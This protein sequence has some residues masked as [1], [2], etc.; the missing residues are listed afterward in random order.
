VTRDEH[1]LRHV[2]LHQHLDELLADYLM[3]HDGALP[4][5]TGMM[6]FLSWSHQQTVEPA[7]LPVE[8]KPN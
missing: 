8:G 3:H 1:K 2:M 7:E 6:D 5:R 4:S